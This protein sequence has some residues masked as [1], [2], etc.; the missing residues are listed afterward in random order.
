[1]PTGQ[2]LVASST[3]SNPTANGKPTD[4]GDLD[5]EALL[6]EVQNT[7]SH[8]T[9]VPSKV[10]ASY[11]RLPQ[12]ENH[13]ARMIECSSG[14]LINRGFTSFLTITESSSTDQRG[15]S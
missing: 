7:G 3:S 5:L 11:H 8:M 12:T 9:E 1:M 14:S 6:V 15:P 4:F 13:R 2:R 10:F